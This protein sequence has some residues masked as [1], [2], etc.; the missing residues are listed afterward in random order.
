MEGAF[1]IFAEVMREEVTSTLPRK[2]AAFALKGALRAVRGR[3]DYAEIG[4]APLL[5]VN[6]VVIVAHGRSDERAFKHAVRAGKTAAE[7]RLPEK[8]RDELSNTVIVPEA[9]L[10]DST[11]AK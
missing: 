8:I 4:G 7:L 1:T 11:I 5:G 6:G 10:A 2:L 9:A 3:M